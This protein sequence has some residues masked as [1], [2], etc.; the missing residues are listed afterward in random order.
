MSPYWLARPSKDR[1][2]IPIGQPLASSANRHAVPDQYDHQQYQKPYP[3]I[4][5]VIY[6][7][8]LLL[9]SSFSLRDLAKL[10]VA[11]GF[12]AIYPF[13]LYCYLKF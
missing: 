1:C 5:Y 4:K 2:F 3:V 10:P 11:K 12:L 7:I 8:L 13:Y 9:L 6:H